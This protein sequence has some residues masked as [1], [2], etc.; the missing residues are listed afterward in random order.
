MFLV[1]AF[2]NQGFTKIKKIAGSRLL[3]NKAIT[4]IPTNPG[5]DTTNAKAPQPSNKCFDVIVD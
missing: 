3:F 4:P 1:P 5:N 2:P